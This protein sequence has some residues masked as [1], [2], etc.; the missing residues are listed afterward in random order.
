MSAESEWPE[1]EDLPE[2]QAATEWT[3]RVPSHSGPPSWP[4]RENVE[5]ALESSF[6]AEIHQAVVRSDVNV[7]EAL[8]EVVRMRIAAGERAHAELPRGH[9][10]RLGGPYLD[11]EDPPNGGVREPRRDP[12]NGPR[13]APSLE[14]PLEG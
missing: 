5:Q 9:P 4:A 8:Q 6:A 3:V 14:T 12:P 2:S 1:R 11:D 7:A 13:D 10:D